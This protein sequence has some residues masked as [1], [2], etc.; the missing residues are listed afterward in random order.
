M[1]R[2]PPLAGR[3]RFAGLV[4]PDEVP[5]HLAL[6]NV[7]V[8]LSRREGLAR[9]LPQAL[10]AGRP[11]VAYDC[12][13]AAEVCLEGETGHLIPPGDQALL[14][15]R[16]ATLAR[17]PAH[18]AALAARGREFVRERFPTERMVDD[19]DRLYREWF[20]RKALQA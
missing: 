11:V 1:A 20:Q 12:D 14:V 18:A 19:L 15:E 4:R 17:D 9:V 5:A 10:A 6:M 16:L 8:H 13:G 2:Q 3:V 7:L